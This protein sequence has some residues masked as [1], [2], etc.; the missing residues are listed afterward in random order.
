MTYYDNKKKFFNEIL[1]IIKTQKVV[2]R[3]SLYYFA[4]TNYGYGET[5]TDRFLEVLKK[6]GQIKSIW[7][8]NILDEIIT[9]IDPK[10]NG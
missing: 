9:Y 6:T 4:K 5:T 3:N 2:E 1:T 10:Q 7:D 8:I